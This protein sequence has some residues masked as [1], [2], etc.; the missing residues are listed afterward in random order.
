MNETK[1]EMMY[2]KQAEMEEWIWEDE[3]MRGYYDHADQVCCENLI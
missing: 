1:Q 3:M 2:E